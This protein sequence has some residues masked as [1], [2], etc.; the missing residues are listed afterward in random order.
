MT[1]NNS[2]SDICFVFEHGT[3]CAN[4]TT[5]GSIGGLWSA[6]GENIYY[7]SGNVSIGDDLD[8]G[9]NLN[10][11]Q[12][13]TVNGIMFVNDS[14]VIGT[15]IPTQNAQVTIKNNYGVALM[16]F[17]SLSSFS[18][19]KFLRGGGERWALYNGG[20]D[21]FYIREDGSGVRVI[22]KEGGEFQIL[23][24]LN[25]SKDAWVGKNLDVSGNITG[26]QIYG[27]IWNR[28]TGGFTTVDLITPDVYVPITQLGSDE[29][30][31]FTSDTQNLTA[32]V[33]GLYQVTMTMSV[34]K[35]AVSTYGTKIF[36]EGVSQDKCYSHFE[37]TANVGGNP[38]ITCFVRLTAG[39]RVYVG[40]DD[41]SNPVNDPAINNMNL[42]LVRVGD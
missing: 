38:A 41:H 11:S 26:N 19:L 16:A 23:N 37:T 30:N 40:I 25:V 39:Q 32:Q 10:V 12:N 27:G 35:G 28:T 29:L 14:L 18:M 4:F 7:N 24:F 33:N 42:N 15:K 8:V 5:Y 3:K 9:N 13:A 36:V 2:P 1:T 21:D 17:D 6:N 34:E 20:S 22:I 31:G